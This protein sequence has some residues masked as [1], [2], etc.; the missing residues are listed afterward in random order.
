MLHLVNYPLSGSEDTRRCLSRIRHGD[1][2]LFLANGVFSVAGNLEG[3]DAIMGSLDRIQVYVSGPDLDVRG[4]SRDSLPVGIG[5]VD[6]DG[7]VDLAV[8]HAP[9]HSWFK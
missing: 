5:V 4:I 3:L 8:R 7:F 6:D 1:V 9:I 2:L